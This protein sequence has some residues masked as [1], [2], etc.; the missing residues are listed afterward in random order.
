MMKI[1]HPKNVKE[2]KE[3]EDMKD[4]GE[5]HMFNLFA[6]AI[7]DLY[8]GIVDKYV[9]R[10]PALWDEFVMRLSAGEMYLVDP[11]PY[12]PVPTGPTAENLCP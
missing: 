11:D 9:R 5:L 12:A 10:T 3:D 6:E 4:K 8:T 2:L 1:Q 7:E